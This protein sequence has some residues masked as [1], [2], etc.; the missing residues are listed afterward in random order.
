MYNKRLT[1]T[2]VDVVC[3]L[4]HMEQEM[5]KLTN[6]V[7]QLVEAQ[8]RPPASSVVTTDSVTHSYLRPECR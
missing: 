5:H 1:N 8:R 3:N 2:L 6:R 4:A 7:N